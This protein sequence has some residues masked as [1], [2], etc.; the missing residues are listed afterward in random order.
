MKKK[1]YNVKWYMSWKFWFF[2]ASALVFFLF[3]WTEKQI[4]MKQPSEGWS[5]GFEI[6]DEGADDYRKQDIAMLYT[7]DGFVSAYIAEENI[8]LLVIDL[9]GDIIFRKQIDFPEIDKQ[10]VLEVQSSERGIQV[11][12]TDRNELYVIEI[13]PSTYQV[14]DIKS[15]TE[16]SKHIA[17][18]GPYIV[19][20]DDSDLV[21]F[22][23]NKLIATYTDFN[24]L[25]RLTINHT[26]DNVYIGLNSAEGG[27]LLK[28]ETAS[29]T[30]TSKKMLTPVDQRVL[31][32]FKDFFV[33]DGM[34][35]VASSYYDRFGGGSPTAI[36]IW[37][38]DEASF[39]TN[40]HMIFYH[41]PTDLD[42]IILDVNGDEVTYILG[43]T[44]TGDIE[45]RRIARYP[46]TSR[47]TFTNVS[48][49][50][51]KGDILIENTRLTVS[52]MYPIGYEYFK[53]DDADLVFWVDRDAKGTTLKMA[54]ESD[55]WITRANRAFK[56]NYLGL[57]YA[58]LVYIGTTPYYGVVFSFLVI[59]PFYRW[60]IGFIVAQMLYKKF[61]PF[62]LEDKKKHIFYAAILV[63][64]II[65]MII[66]ASPNSDFAH[67]GHMYPYLFGNQ[68]V[69]T[70][71]PILTT[72]V[73]LGLTFLWCKQH[74]YYIEKHL[75]FA[76]YFGLEI[77]FFLFVFMMYFVSALLKM[78]Y[79]M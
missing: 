52:R 51:R 73:S 36:G 58:T 40:E 15:L 30:M 47:G 56:V 35:T 66:V 18:K 34:L 59:L 57:L 20:G 13:D 10:R 24:D 69:M 41:V 14:S 42:P 55:E 67:F 32:Y 19:A 8:E 17:S 75:H 4:E 27:K 44:Q 33:K 49:L 26:D 1:L 7:N 22:K 79:M 77:Y 29:E 62:E 3:M 21:L 54:G 43:M 39:V 45:N 12:V 28:F 60:I 9:L 74:Y 50:T 71:L 37:H 16:H 5:V 2:F 65:K 70:V 11:Y 25:K 64:F 63:T 31:G 61:A 46:Q 68:L 76:I 38:I 48:R 72:L 53:M 78:N 23:D 6:L